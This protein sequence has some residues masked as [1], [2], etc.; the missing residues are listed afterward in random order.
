MAIL[1]IASLDA[2]AEQQVKLPSNMVKLSKE[3]LEQVAS[4]GD[5][6]AQF[7]LGL[8]YETQSTD[9]DR[10]KKSAHWYGLA[11]KQAHRIAQ[12]N[13]GVLF[14]T[15]SGVEKDANKALNLWL[16]AARSGH[17]HA[18]FNVARG[19]FLGVGLAE[20]HE[21]AKYW[22]IRAAKQ[23][24]PK[25]Q[26][27]LKELGW[28]D[29]GQES[30]KASLVASNQIQTKTK[31]IDS[32]LPLTVKPDESQATQAN[33]KVGKVKFVDEEINKPLLRS[34][35]RD[36]KEIAVYVSSLD[37]GSIL[38]VLP[39][40]NNLTAFASQQSGWLV[41]ESSEGFPAWV[42]KKF[43]QNQFGYG[44]IT[45]SNVIARSQPIIREDTRFNVFRK[46]EVVRI[47]EEKDQWYKVSLPPK[48]KGWV[49]ESDWRNG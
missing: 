39:S 13:L 21:K 29:S 27:L 33:T 9:K 20:N 37:K 23:G 17:S 19:Y 10:F 46:G 44:K 25:S 35:S 47:L 12:Y 24:E 30:K 2:I 41:V 4:Q 6:E 11:A 43:V 38:T 1:L 31:S 49:K 14:M 42:Y 5:E 40:R 16:S 34:N 45:A 8:F 32:G 22:L 48:F 7:R 15:G 36:D 26:N 28:S 18:Q 3:Q